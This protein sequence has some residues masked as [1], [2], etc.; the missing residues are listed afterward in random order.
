MRLL[1]TA[2][3]TREA[4]DAVRFI[5]N[6]SSGKMGYAVAAAA[7]S[8]GHE[9]CLVSGPVSVKPPRAADVVPVVSAAEMFAA[10]SQ[11]VAWC[12][13][14][15]M[16]AAVADWRPKRPAGTKLKKSQMAPVLEL[17]R[18][19]DILCGIRAAKGER[20]YVGFAAETGNLEQEALRKLKHKGL[21]LIVANDVSRA[22][23]GFAVDTNKVTLFGA[24]GTVSR[25]PLLG[26][27]EVAERIL[28]WLE[29]AVS[30]GPR[31]GST[32]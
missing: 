22:D 19:A 20:V 18:T 2:G 8:R 11:R 5:T 13:A 4:I 29:S 15:V 12:E 3:P 21:D 32:R 27:P 7:L 31:A 1:V 9:V 30:P 6:A 26:K 25:L 24:D 28:D 14:L 17:E 10:V 16:T 23:S